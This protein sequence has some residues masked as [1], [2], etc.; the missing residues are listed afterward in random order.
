MRK[1]NFFGAT[2]RSD[3]DMRP[4]RLLR[5]RGRIGQAPESPLIRSSG[6]EHVVRVGSLVGSVHQSL[7]GSEVPHASH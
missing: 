6:A 1:K 2:S 5:Y 4:D 7:T 3:Y